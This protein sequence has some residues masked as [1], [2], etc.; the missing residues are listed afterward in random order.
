MKA[1]HFGAGKIGRGFIADLLHDTGYENV[2]VD[3]NEKV[4][5]E[6]NKYH[7]YYLYVIEEDYRRKEIDKVSALSPIT[8]EDKVVEAIVEADV[9]T[10][11]VLADN[12]PKIAG[13][14]AKGLKARLEAG[15]ERV[16]VIPC[17][18]ALFNGDLLL[19]ELVKTEKIAEEIGYV[20]KHRKKAS[21]GNAGTGQG[22]R[23]GVVTQL[24]QS[25]FMLEVNRGIR[26]AAKKLSD[27]GIQ[28][29]VREN[30]SVDE[31]EQLEAVRQ[32]EE[33]GIDALAIMPVDS[34]SVR[35]KL[36]ELAD[37]GQIPVVTF[38]TDIV[39][40]YHCHDA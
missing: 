8:E 17:E 33:E 4:N 24:S 14:L 19:K 29:L 16:N 28:V 26:E 40:T 20:P 7:N 25:S 1:V 30:A 31:T 13:T 22:K 32:L 6:L 10:T 18:N 37:E 39:G 38:N 9:V 23:I 21:G 11:A 35:L 12:F 15:K 2:F 34:D 5:E 27:R 36:N 3:V